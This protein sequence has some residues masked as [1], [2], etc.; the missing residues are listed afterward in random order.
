MS[1]KDPAKKLLQCAIEAGSI[2]TNARGKHS[3]NESD[4]K[5]LNE[6]VK[7]ISSAY[8]NLVDRLKECLQILQAFE[9][10]NSITIDDLEDTFEEIAGLCEDVDLACDFHKIGGFNVLVKFLHHVEPRLQFAS[11]DVLAVISQ[12]NEYCQNNLLKD[13]SILQTLLEK[14]LVLS[15]EQE[16]NVAVKCMSA[17]SC[18]IRQNK[19]GFEKFLSS[20]GSI[21][22]LKGI[23]SK[24]IKLQLK[25]M[26]LLSSL[27][28]E[29]SD[30]HIALNSNDFVSALLKVL[31]VDNNFDLVEYALDILVTVSCHSAE[32]RNKCKEKAKE[33]KKALDSL[34]SDHD[35][36]SDRHEITNF[37]NQLQK[38]LHLKIIS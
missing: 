13:D 15:N 34:L 16:C 8:T 6:A 11:A 17:V 25:S 2:S 33:F 12:N 3:I 10:D 1:G 24:T 30:M 5:W 20:N 23:Q 31:N 22:L 19:I 4:R 21:Y 7:N 36:Q 32:F 26:F 37:C 18:L 35:V 38:I 29:S 14:T 27:S 28:K 9:S